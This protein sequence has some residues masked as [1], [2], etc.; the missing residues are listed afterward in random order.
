MIEFKFRQRIDGQFHYW[1]KFGPGFIGPVES[2]KG[3]DNPATTP[4]DLCSGY[5][6]AKGREVFEND[7]LTG[8]LVVSRSPSGQFVATRVVKHP[9]N[10]GQQGREI[11]MAKTFRK[12]EVM[13]NMYDVKEGK[14]GKEK[15]N[16]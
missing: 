4:H 1:G 14:N 12:L 5:L 13:G 2:K 16:I 6:D 10:I 7:I 8:G 11:V 15:S 3:G 9:E